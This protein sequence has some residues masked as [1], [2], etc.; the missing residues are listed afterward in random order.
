MK[1]NGFVA[2]PSMIS[3][4]SSSSFSHMRAISLTSPM[5]TARNVFSSS[6]T[7]SAACVL[8]TGYDRV[9]RLP[10]ER[11]PRLRVQ[12]A[13]VPADDL[14][15][16]ARL[17]DRVARDRRARARTRGRSRVPAC[18]PPRFEPR[19]QDLLGRARDRSCDSSTMSW[20]GRSRCAISSRRR[21]DVGDV[22][23]ARLAQR[24]R[25]ADEDRV[26]RPRSPSKS[27][28][29]RRASFFLHERRD[30]RRRHVLD[31]RAPGADR[32]APSPRRRRSRSRGSPTRANSTAS[33][34]P[35][36]AQPDD[37]DARLAAGDL[38]SRSSCA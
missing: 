37:A 20:P 21:D 18:S 24:R 23:V 38:A 28:C 5:F 3:Q 31:V 10:V 35:D 30:R 26:D 12:H 1:P 11:V 29:D 8:E 14:R 33:G 2:A 13:V 32:F 36:V 6:L 27:R 19:A 15:R 34:R 7:I 22:R 4:T 25:H 16:V 17:V 9:D